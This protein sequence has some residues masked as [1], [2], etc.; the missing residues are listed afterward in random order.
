MCVIVINMHVSESNLEVE[1][2][3]LAG[4]ELANQV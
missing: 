2:I 3:K 1:E 4:K